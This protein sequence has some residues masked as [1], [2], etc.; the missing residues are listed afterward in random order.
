MGTPEER[1]I[2]YRNEFFDP[3]NSEHIRL[4]T[5]YLDRNIGFYII[6]EERVPV[7]NT[8]KA[9]TSF[10]NAVGEIYE[11]NNLFNA[12]VENNIISMN[13]VLN[14]GRIIKID[15]LEDNLYKIIEKKEENYD[16]P[17]IHLV[18]P[19]EHSKK[20]IDYDN[21]G[22]TGGG[23]R[24][25]KRTKLRKSLKRNMRKSRRKSRKTKRRTIRKTRR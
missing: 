20:L 23:R 22:E 21:S 8:I 18:A 11:I 16:Y 17:I 10:T 7:K 13:A 12:F 4:G 25:K 9:Y 6:D 3:N 19:I 14:T 1:Q 15:K 5:K 24:N 2:L